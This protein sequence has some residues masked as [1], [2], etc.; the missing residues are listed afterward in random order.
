MNEKIKQIVEVQYLNTDGVLNLDKFERMEPTNELKPYV[1]EILNGYP[2]HKLEI[3][4]NLLDNKSKKEL[5]RHF[6]DEGKEEYAQYIIYEK[7]EEILNSELKKIEKPYTRYFR[8]DSVVKAHVKREFFNG[9]PDE[10]VLGYSVALAQ[11]KAFMDEHCPH[12]TDF[13]KYIAN[14]G[15][16]VQL[17]GIYARRISKSCFL[18]A[19]AISRERIYTEMMLR[20]KKDELTGGITKEFLFDMI[21]SGNVDMCVIKLCVKLEAILKSCYGLEGDLIEMLDGYFQK[22]PREENMRESLS[23]LRMYRNCLVH[24]EYTDI[25]ITPIE[26]KNCIDYICKMEK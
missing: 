20:L 24:A 12:E 4:I 21:K 11:R 15:S 8:S 2:I 19:L 3:L 9:F 7:K 10:K 17:F 25:V 23:R 26:L 6:I 22:F 18:D 5:F 13:E 1:K 16:K 14:S